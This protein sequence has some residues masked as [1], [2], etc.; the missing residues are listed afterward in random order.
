[1]EVN[2]G[3]ILKSPRV[4]L[5]LITPHCIL[6]YFL[7]IFSLIFAS[8]YNI[9]CWFTSN[10]IWSD[11]SRLSERA[12]ESVVWPWLFL[13]WLGILFCFLCFLRFLFFF[14]SA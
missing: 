2:W 4:I 9:Q 1:M 13:P 7:D 6:L 5:N 3:H 12:S 11:T 14:F 10:Y 8:L